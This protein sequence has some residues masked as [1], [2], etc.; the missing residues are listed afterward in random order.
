MER[1]RVEGGIE[2]AK[3]RYFNEAIFC[4]GNKKCL[5]P[6]IKVSQNSHA[7]VS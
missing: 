4:L 2:K 5:L 3:D 6:H 7:Q 1:D